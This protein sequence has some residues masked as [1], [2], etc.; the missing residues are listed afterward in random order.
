MATT[1]EIL[2]ANVA[3][4]RHKLEHRSRTE[5]GTS[6]SCFS[7]LL[8]LAIDQMLSGCDEFF[9]SNRGILSVVPKIHAHKNR[10]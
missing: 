8:H 2:K 10:M 7:V 1:D 3:Q 9:Q 6:A 4:P 5:V